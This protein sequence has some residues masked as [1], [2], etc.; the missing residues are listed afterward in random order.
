MIVD[1]NHIGDAILNHTKGSMAPRMSMIIF[2][3]NIYI[4]QDILIIY[5]THPLR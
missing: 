4:K 1:K 3:T 2:H 5:L